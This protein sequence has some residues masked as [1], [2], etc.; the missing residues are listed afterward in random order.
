MPALTFDAFQ[1]SLK[2]GEILPAY[3]FHGEEELLKDDAVRRLVA[4]G[5]EAGTRDF[6]LD[7]RRAADLLPEEFTAL[8]LTPPML[9]A[10]RAIL[11]SEVEFLQQKKPRAQALRAAALRYLDR[12]S[13]ET[14][15]VLIA[16]AGEKAD[17]DLVSRAASVPFEALPPDRVARWVRHRAA[18]EGLAMDDGAV[19]HL[20]AV[21]G[22]NLPQLAAEI[23]KLRAAVLG[24]PV[25]ADDV[26]ELV[27][28]RH[29]ET[30]Y[31]F[32]D[33]VTGRRFVPAVEMLPRL[34]AA[35]GVSGV[36]VVA[37]L[38]TA[39]VGVA[40]ARAQLDD[41]ASPAVAQER[42][43]RALY[44][45]RPMGLRVWKDEAT[46]WVRDAA[47]WSAAELD[48]AFTELLRADRRLKSTTLASESD[49]VSEAILALVGQGVGAA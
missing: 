20:M 38:T 12:P 39:L 19:Q 16:S 30:V 37:A 9:A 5:V 47:N 17:S 35:P 14:L 7:R 46:R 43:V 22:D 3:Y 2:K 26:A 44:D 32:V 15:L 1:R 6:N 10:R 8:V 29:G 42:L 27:G 24:R 40:L 13:P 41:G 36:R 33:A 49:L 18:E 34:L 45:T 48:R 4:A 31:D 25:T 23:S 28:V 21:V 11:V